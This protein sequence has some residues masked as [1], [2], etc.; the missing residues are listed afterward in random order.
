MYTVYDRIK[1]SINIKDMARTLNKLL[2]NENYQLCSEEARRSC[3]Y[4][5]HTCDEC[6]VKR[7]MEDENTI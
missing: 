3:E 2:E 5:A 4:D 1:N 7:L 6:I